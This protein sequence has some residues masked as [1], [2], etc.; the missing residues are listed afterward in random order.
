MNHDPNNPSI[1]PLAGGAMVQSKKNKHRALPSIKIQQ[2]TCR[3]ST[4]EIDYLELSWRLVGLG[5]VL[6]H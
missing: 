3:F 5:S 2:S 4:E 1:S 6:W